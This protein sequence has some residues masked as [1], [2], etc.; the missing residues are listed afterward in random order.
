VWAPHDR[1]A[2]PKESLVLGELI[3]SECRNVQWIG[4]EGGA[5]V[6]AASAAMPRWKGSIRMPGTV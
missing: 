3:V 5:N 2:G 6:R 1:Q 4:H